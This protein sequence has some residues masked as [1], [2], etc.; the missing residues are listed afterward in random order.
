MW[1]TC[2]DAALLVLVDA[3][4]E[5][6]EPELLEGRVVVLEEMSEV[7]TTIQNRRTQV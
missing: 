6:V 3:A 1:A 5:V 2:A 7:N 4:P